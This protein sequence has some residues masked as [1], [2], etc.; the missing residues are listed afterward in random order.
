ML[1]IEDHRVFAE[2]LQAR[3]RREPDLSPVDVAY[4]G[5]EACERITLG[6]PD[7]VV[8]DLLL[9]DASGLEVVQYARRVSPASVVVMLTGVESPDAVADGL[10][11]G[12]RAWLPKTVDASHLVRVIHGVCRGETWIAPDLLGK[13][14][15]RLVGANA[16]ATDPLTTLTLRERE[17]LRYLV[18]GLTRAQIADRM[19]VSGNTVRTHVQN[20]L[21]KLG[22]HSTLETVALALRYG[23]TASAPRGTRPGAPAGG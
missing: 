23:I 15:P 16:A 13:V 1:V 6:T 18:D 8:L 10:R 2:A 20:V 5:A 3:L 14:M 4:T 19:H 21:T 9:G 17:V 7:V 12:V 11:L 22:T